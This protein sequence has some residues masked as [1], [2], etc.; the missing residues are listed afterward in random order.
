MAEG[1]RQMAEETAVLR[2]LPICYLPICY[3]PSAICHLPSA[4]SAS[5]A[6]RLTAHSDSVILRPP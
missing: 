4:L 1:R 2:H 3:L 6:V 5:L